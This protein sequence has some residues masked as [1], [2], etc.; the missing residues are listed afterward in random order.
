M[1]SDWEQILKDRLQLYGHRNWFVIADSVAL[2]YS[3][4]ASGEDCLTQPFCSGH[5]RWLAGP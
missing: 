3:T 4:F 2:V 5:L 1:K